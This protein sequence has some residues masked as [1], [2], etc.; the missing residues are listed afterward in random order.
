MPKWGTL[1]SV[2]RRQGH[3]RLRAVSDFELS[4]DVRHVALD[5]PVTDVNLSAMSLLLRPDATSVRTFLSRSLSAEI[6]ARLAS[7]PFDRAERSG[8]FAESVGET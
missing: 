2:P 7:S 8:T 4:H 3:R 6:G 5:G 1:T